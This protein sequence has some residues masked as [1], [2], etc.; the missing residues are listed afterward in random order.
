LGVLI[1]H[2]KG[3]YSVAPGVGGQVASAS[4]D[5]TVKLWDVGSTGEAPNQSSSMLQE[6]VGHNGDV[7]SCSF[8]DN[9]QFIVSGS[10]DKTVQVFKTN[11]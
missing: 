2:Q 3:I 6:F 5:C 10:D 8:I 9:G 4:R 11:P 1:G 7:N